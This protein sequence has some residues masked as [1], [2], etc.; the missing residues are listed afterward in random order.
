VM[1]VFIAGHLKSLKKKKNDK[2]Y[3]IFCHHH[4]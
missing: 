4:D 2:Y 1:Y 3:K